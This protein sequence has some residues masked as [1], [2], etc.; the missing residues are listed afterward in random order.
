MDTSVVVAVVSAAAAVTSAVLVFRSSGRATN[1][2][3]Q[4]EH[5]QWVK[6]MR[7][8][9]AEARKEVEQLREKVR[10]L[11]R[12][13]DIVTHEADHWIAQYQLVHRTAWRPGITLE[14]LR[15]MLGP[16]LPRPD[17]GRSLT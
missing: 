11:S 16:D 12:S 7:V 13:L 17:N 6:D 15:A 10:A 3:E 9:A 4:A 2:N 1:V 5:L 8:D 14:Q